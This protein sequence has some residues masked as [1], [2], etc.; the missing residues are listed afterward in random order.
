MCK[1]E[2]LLVGLHHY[3]QWLEGSRPSA[4]EVE[5]RR[6]FAPRVQQLVQEFQPNVVLDETPD[7]DNAELLAVLP[8]PP[9]PIDISGRRKRERGF[10]VE[11]SMHYLCP[12]VDAV[13]ERYWRRQLYRIV[14]CRTNARVLMFVGAKHLEKSYIKRLCVSGATH[15]LRT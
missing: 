1:S 2:M 9:I 13:R 7:T 8:V 3:Y 14:R 6:R 4:L 11:R 15:K 10:N 5:Q 12:F